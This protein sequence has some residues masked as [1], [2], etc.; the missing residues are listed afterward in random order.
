MSSKTISL[1][2]LAGI[3][4]VSVCG[5]APTIVG[6]DAGVYSQTRLHAV[7]SK[8]ITTVYE[9]TLLSLDNLELSVTEKAKDVFYAKIVAKGADGK[10]ITVRI[11][12]AGDKSSKISIKVGAFGDQERSTIIYEQI[13]KSL[14]PSTK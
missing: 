4:L 1:I 6:T 10:Y 14:T 12:P 8:D 2:F 13:K 11:E 3:L 7:V 9:A 5:C